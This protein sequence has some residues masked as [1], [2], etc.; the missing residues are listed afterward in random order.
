MIGRAIQQTNQPATVVTGTLL[1]EF[2]NTNLYDTGTD[3]V[4]A[5]SCEYKRAFHNYYPTIGVI[6]NIEHDHHDCYPTWEEY[7]ESFIQFAYQCEE[8]VVIE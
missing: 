7:L 4:V 3:I 6:L 5:E 2:N 8:I 1:K